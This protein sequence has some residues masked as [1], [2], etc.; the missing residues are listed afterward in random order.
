[1]ARAATIIDLFS[2]PGGLGEGFCSI[3]REDGSRPFRIEVSIEKEASAHRTL[4]LRAF[5]RQF[6]TPPEAYLDWLGS[7]R[8]EP[9]WSRLFPEAW[10][11]ACHEAICAELGTP[12]ATRM[13]DARIDALRAQSDGPTLLIGGPPCQ[14]YSLVGRARNAG[15]AGYRAEEDHRHFLYEEYCRVLTR[16][17]PTIFVMENVKGILSSSV[18]GKRIFEQ[19]VSDLRSAGPGYVLHAL[20][21]QAG[22]AAPRSADFLVRAEDHGAPQARH[23][24]IIVG[25][26]KD[27]AE[28]LPEGLRPRLRPSNRQATVDEAIGG[29]PALRSGLSRGDDVGLWLEVMAEALE[30]VEQAA[31]SVVLEHPAKFRQALDSTRAQLA[32]TAGKG[33]I[34]RRTTPKRPSASSPLQLWL[35]GDAGG[36]LQGHATRG[37]MPGD[38]ARYLF[39]ACFAASQRDGT[40]EP[41]PE[42]RHVGRSPR[43]EDFPAALAPRHANWT[44]GKFND[45]FRVQV[46]HKASTTITSHISKDGHYYIHPD[47]AQCRSLTVREAA[48]LQTFPDDYVFLGNRTQ[49]YVQVGNAVPPFLARQIAEA[50]LPIFDGLGGVMK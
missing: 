22:R 18:S 48:R 49:Q 23:R 40:A 26:R 44:S 31:G 7:E 5:L 39:A 35:E 8:P 45:R 38:L 3:R 6:D 47:A 10:A 13:L 12:E 1:M 33:R 19:V 4:R 36:R 2:G 28:G 41:H 25:I 27:V 24:V 42:D 29:L 50:L 11:A 37:H 21:G 9:D 14:A 16:L 43:A 30:R 34:A 46:A 17:E 32:Q 20:S 15:T